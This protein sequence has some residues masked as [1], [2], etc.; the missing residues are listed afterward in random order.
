MAIK[1]IFCG[2]SKNLCDVSHLLTL[3]IDKTYQGYGF[4]EVEIDVEPNTVYTFSRENSNPITINGG[5]YLGIINQHITPSGGNSQWLNHRTVP[6]LCHQNVQ[7]TS[8]VDG[9]L[10]IFFSPGAYNKWQNYENP[11]GY[12]QLEKS[13]TATEYVP[14]E[15]TSYKS[16]MKVSDNNFITSFDGRLLCKTNNL[17]NSSTEV[18][19]PS[20][21]D[22]SASSKRILEDGKWYIGLSS[23][24]YYSKTHITSY[25]INSNNV[26]LR[27]GA[28]GYGL[29]KCLYVEPN[30][31]YS[32]SYTSSG[33]YPSVR[34]GFYQE[35]GTYIS[36]TSANHFTIPENCKFISIV[37]TANRND[38]E[39]YFS[40][41]KIEKSSII[42]DYVPYNYV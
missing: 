37:F 40:N 19:V 38:A 13:S 34:C 11:F 20:N 1:S 18:G 31:T 12:L 33:F 16:I 5:S 29:V 32:I 23:N 26:F 27:T 15:L 28:S 14:Y 9:K 2:K 4:W 42:T 39:V 3:P 7:I 41:I 22:F 24:N 30:T 35:D 17:F 6:G 10:W 21:T 25:S 36:S 8:S